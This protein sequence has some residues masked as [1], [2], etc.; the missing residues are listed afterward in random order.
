MQR[1]ILA[2]FFWIPKTVW[3]PDFT[4]SSKDAPGFE[5]SQTVD[6]YAQGRWS[7]AWARL[8]DSA[9]FVCGI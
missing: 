4:H 1:S 6:R 9:Q 5:K 7:C 8:L 2:E 3:L